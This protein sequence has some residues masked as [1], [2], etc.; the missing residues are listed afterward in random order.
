MT[1]FLIR[2]LF[3]L[4]SG[5]L[6]YT[7]AE[8]MSG[9]L[10]QMGPHPYAFQGI[11]VGVLVA[12]AIIGLEMLFRRRPVQA[13]SAIIFGVIAG[14]VLATMLSSVSSLVITENT[15]QR[16]NF[17]SKEQ[18][19]GMIQICFVAVCCYLCVTLIYSTRDKFRFII[20]YVE[21]QKEEKGTRPILVDTSAI[22]DG[23][24]AV[25]CDTHI[26]DATLLVP[27][28][29]LQELQH[30]ADSPDRLR[31]NRGR[32]GMEILHRIQRDDKVEVQIHDGR[33]ARGSNVDAKLLSLANQLQCRI[34]TC[35]YNLAKIADIQDVEVIN[36][37]DVATSLRRIAVQGEEMSVRIVRAGDE[38]GQG[39]GYIPDGTM[40][41]VENARQCVNESV[42]FVITNVLQTSAGRMIFGRM[43]DADEGPPNGRKGTG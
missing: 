8:Q 18:M 23:R 43:K 36:I 12:G 3:L 35:D 34:L 26:F 27:K 39:V 32:R 33:S 21:F 11:I 15:A 28:F 30:V 29:V 22:I 17:R 1:E 2:A 10:F 14:F 5:A 40:V 7:I 20:P 38:P 37:N 42:T 41:V 13:V 6:G 25:L 24:L 19:A 16:W 9:G 4:I 31:R